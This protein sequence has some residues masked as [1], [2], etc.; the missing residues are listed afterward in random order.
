MNRRKE[1]KSHRKPGENETRIKVNFLENRLD[2]ILNHR[3]L[4]YQISKKIDW[5]KFEKFRAVEK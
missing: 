4:L 2:Q 1:W 5:E 3:H